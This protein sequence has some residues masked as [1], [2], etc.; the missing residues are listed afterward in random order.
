MN[1]QNKKIILVVIFIILCVVEVVAV[2]HFTYSYISRLPVHVE[3]T[4]YEAIVIKSKKEP[5]NE[6]G[7]HE[8]LLTISVDGNSDEVLR[9]REYEPGEKLVV[10]KQEF[11]VNGRLINVC[12]L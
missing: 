10:T 8:Y 5:A 6:W 1:S 2:G 3:E 4:E 11:Y 12:Y 9:T 7:L